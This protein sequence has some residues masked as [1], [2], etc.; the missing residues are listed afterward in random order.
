M[1]FACRQ[2]DVS[3]TQ[4]SGRYN[5]LSA[6]KQISLITQHAQYKVSF[7]IAYLFSRRENCQRAIFTINSHS[8]GI[9]NHLSIRASYFHFTKW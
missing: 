8:Q 3:L 7:Q 1:S 6:W 4:M 2:S 5:A 9:I